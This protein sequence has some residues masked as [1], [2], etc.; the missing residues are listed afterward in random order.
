M[1]NDHQKKKEACAVRLQNV[2]RSRLAKKLL[3][4]KKESLQLERLKKQKQHTALRNVSATQIQKIIR[5]NLNVHHFLQV[6]KGI[7]SLQCL[8]R[9]RAF[10]NRVQNRVQTALRDEAVIKLS[11]IHI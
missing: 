9:R 6:K 8:A 4:R 3:G 5:R 10:R 11:L 2:V 7:V 1:L